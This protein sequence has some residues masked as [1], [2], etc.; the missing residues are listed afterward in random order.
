MRFV[1]IAVLGLLLLAPSA[2]A[3]DFA[4]A[5]KH[6]KL[7]RSAFDARHYAAAAVEFGPAPVS[8]PANTAPT[9]SAGP[10]SSVVRPDTATL[11][12]SVTDDGLPTGSSVT[13]VWEQVSGPGTATFAAADQASTTATFSA[14]GDYVLRLTGS[15][16]ELSQ[17][18]DVAVTVADPAPLPGPAGAGDVP[19]RPAVDDA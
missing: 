16:G 17:S 1:A 7:A 6:F 2:Q 14:A 15:D 8:Q 5:S 9:A 18:D 3:Q 10:D 11:A 13:A 19:V 12:G 4:A